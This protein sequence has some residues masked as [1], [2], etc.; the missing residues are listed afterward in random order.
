MQ[1]L[2]IALL[3]LFCACT[4]ANDFAYSAIE[5]P[6]PAFSSSRILYT[7]KKG[8]RALEVEF[9]FSDARCDLFI[10][11]HSGAIASSPEG[12]TTLLIKTESGQREFEVD[13]LSGNQRVHLSDEASKT[14][15]NSLLENQPVTLFLN[16]YQTTLSSHG[17]EKA[18]KNITKFPPAT[19]LAF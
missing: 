14:I 8:P 7:K 16:T 6:D 4:K 13:L 15:L 17:F 5:S 19:L 12:T 9:L 1:R 3:V 2:K 18:L 10:N 11:I